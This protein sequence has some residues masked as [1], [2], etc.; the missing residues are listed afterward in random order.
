MTDS[1]KWV[2]LINP[3][4]PFVDRAE[5]IR[6]QDAQ[7]DNPREAGE[8]LESWVQ[9][10]NVAAGVMLLGQCDA[11]EPKPEAPRDWKDADL[12]AIFGPEED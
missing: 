2:P 5:E 8:S 12:A 6:V 10:C 3:G 4:T 7:R 11:I 1:P 9:R